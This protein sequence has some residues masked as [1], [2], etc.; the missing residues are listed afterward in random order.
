MPER[1]TWNTVSKILPRECVQR[2]AT[3]DGGSTSKF[4][5]SYRRQL[6]VKGL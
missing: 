4:S 1:I 3:L 5:H 2:L 6:L